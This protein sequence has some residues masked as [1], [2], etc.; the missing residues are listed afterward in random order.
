MVRRING[1]TRAL[2][3]LICVLATFA[4]GA[5][6]AMALSVSRGESYWL[7]SSSGQVF[8]FGNARNYGSEAGKRFRGQMVGIVSTPNG[9]GY[10]LISSI[11]KQFSFGDA[12]LYKY[13]SS[14]LQKLSG[15]VSVKDLHGRI[16]GV[17]VAKLAVAKPATVTTTTTT[18]TGIQ[19]TTAPLTTTTSTST[20]PTTTVTTPTTTSTTSGGTPQPLAVTTGSLPVG[21]Y[22]YTYSTALTAS[23][24][25]PSYS[26]TLASG[27]LPAGLSLQADGTISGTPMQTGT[28]RFGVEVA[29][30]ASPDQTATASVSIT[31]DLGSGNWSGY[32]QQDASGGTSG[33]AYTGASGTFTVPTLDSA[34]V[35]GEYLAEWVGID[36]Y[37]NDDLIQAGVELDSNGSGGETVQPWWEILPADETPITTMSVASGDSVSVTLTKTAT[38]CTITQHHGPSESGYDWTIALD[39][40][41]H[42]DDSFSTSQCYAGPGDSAEW[43]VEAPEVDGSISTLAPFAPAVGFSELSSS[44]TYTSLDEMV[45]VN[46]D[47]EVVAT[48]SPFD[49]NGFTVAY[50]DDVP[51]A[52]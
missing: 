38:T 23:G 15:H 28:Y 40:T 52:P 6:A 51:A 46:N 29:D 39:D 1:S 32:A 42:T 30:S 36:G 5:G 3:A 37:D 13:R 48:P 17:A 44:Q 43:I 50:G 19:T 2:A 21:A 14:K 22:D 27:S 12:H 35:G 33:P 18:T 11:G 7:V 31:I 26:W 25:T 45:I 16:V 41:S 24:G 4:C 9:K 10:W 20:T 8:A 49:T 47:G 34:D